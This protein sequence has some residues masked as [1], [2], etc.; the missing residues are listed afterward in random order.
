MKNVLQKFER[1]LYTNR[2]G[3]KLAFVWDSWQ[4][5][6]GCVYHIVGESGNHYCAQHVFKRRFPVKVDGI[7]IEKGA[8]KTHYV[9]PGLLYANTQKAVWVQSIIGG[10]VHFVNYYPFT[11]T[12][13]L[14][15]EVGE[16][17]DYLPYVIDDVELDQ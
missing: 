11:S 7:K 4:E 3:S 5:T 17:L 14:K 2:D 8:R 16:F 13:V 6:T 1:G 15:M 10:I 9:E 12:T